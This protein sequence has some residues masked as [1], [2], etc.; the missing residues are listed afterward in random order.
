[1]KVSTKKDNPLVVSCS[2]SVL[3]DFHLQKIVIFYLQEKKLF[4]RFVKIMSSLKLGLEDSYL[5]PIIFKAHYI[6]F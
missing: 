2:K 6:S 3:E 1:M 5:Q 4:D